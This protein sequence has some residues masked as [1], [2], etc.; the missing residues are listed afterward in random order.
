[1][2]VLTDAEKA[3]IGACF[4]EDEAI[5]KACARL[6]KQS[7]VQKSHQIIFGVI[8]DLASQHVAVDL[9]TVANA[10]RNKVSSEYLAELVDYV[11]TA[12]NVDYYINL[13]ETESQRHR[14]QKLAQAIIHC[15][16][17]NPQEVINKAD[18]ELMRIAN[19]QKSTIIHIKDALTSATQTLDKRGFLGLTT[20]WH[21]FDKVL[22]GLCKKN[23]YIIAARP[24]VGKTAFVLSLVDKVEVPT[25]IFSLEMG[26]DELATRMCCCKGMIS[27]HNTRC[28]NLSIDESAVWLETASRLAGREILIDDT[29]ALSMTQLRAKARM[30]KR[31][32]NIGLVVVDYLQL[33]TGHGESRQQEISYISRNLKVLSKELDI[34]VIA[35]SQLNRALENR[36]DKRPILADLRESGSIEQDADVVM[37]IYRQSMYDDEAPEHEAE[38][39]IDKNRQGRCGTIAFHWNGEYCRFDEVKAERV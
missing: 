17:Q 11:P 29:A 37:F 31:T 13:V 20:N 2:S 19:T 9:V 21:T 28:H 26:A 39:I 33:M 32:K 22:S 3:V 25:A 5:D 27:M 4:L 14:L 15:K 30:L 23:L 12:A 6:T 24:G 16:D 38:L 35:L 7:F 1:V 36:Q 34:P 10:V 8:E 18:A